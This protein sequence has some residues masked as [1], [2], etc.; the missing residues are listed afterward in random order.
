[1]SLRSLIQA[2]VPAT[3]RGLVTALSRQA[4]RQSVATIQDQ[5]MQ[6]VRQLLPNLTR[7]DREYV[8]EWI[9][10]AVAARRAAERLNQNPNEPPTNRTPVSTTWTPETGQRWRYFV[11]VVVRDPVTGTTER[12]PVEFISSEPMSQSQ[13][14]RQMRADVSAGL[15]WRRSLSPGSGNDRATL[16]ETIIV[17]V[18]RGA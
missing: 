13:I 16:V 8:R 15:I 12:V 18:E 7:R 17:T 10:E 6:R 14:D 2:R 11:I 4:L 9:G 3:V 1:M 5:L